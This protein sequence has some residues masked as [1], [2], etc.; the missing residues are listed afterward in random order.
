MEI[1]E[2]D[3]DIRKKE[4][5]DEEALRKAAEEKERLEREEEEKRK[6][7]EAKKY[8][9]TVSNIEK[10]K[11]PFFWGNLN[12]YLNEQFF[13][14]VFNKTPTILLM[15]EGTEVS[16]GKSQIISNINAC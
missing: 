3:D 15:Q 2:N 4:E 5:I 10:S 1:L 11:E 14:F 16:Q 9:V 6:K 8:D 13:S 7:E 12:K